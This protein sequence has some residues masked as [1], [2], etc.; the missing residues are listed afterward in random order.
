VLAGLAMVY[1]AKLQRIPDTRQLNVNTIAS[2]DDLLP[3]LD[4]FPNRSE[5]APELYEY[6]Q[7]ARPLRNAGALAGIVPRRQLARLKPLIVVRTW[8]EFR[9]QLLL[10][11]ALYF[12]GFYL[13]ALVWRLTGYRSDRAFL[14]AL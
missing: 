14:A 11:A 6:L 9:N 1:S 2:Q 3:I 12:G 13:V 10:S 4:F 8:R 5:L 7:R